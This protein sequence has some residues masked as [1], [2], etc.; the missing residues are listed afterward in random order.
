MIQGCVFL[1]WVD[2][3]VLSFACLCGSFLGALVGQSP[4]WFLIRTLLLAK[5]AVVIGIRVFSREQ[6]LIENQDQASETPEDIWKNCLR[7]SDS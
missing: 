5:K 4:V 6:K 7:G 3:C 1:T 2:L